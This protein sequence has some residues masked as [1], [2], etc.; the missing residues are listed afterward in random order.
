MVFKWSFLKSCFVYSRN[1]NFNSTS[2]KQLVALETN[3]VFILIM[4]H[5]FLSHQFFF[6]FL[7]ILG[8]LF[9]FPI[10]R[11]FLGKIAYYHSF[12]YLFVS[13][14]K[15]IF[16]PI[17]DDHLAFVERKMMNAI[18]PLPFQQQF[19]TVPDPH[20]TKREISINTIKVGKHDKRKPT[21]VLL[22]GFGAALGFWVCNLKALSESANVY[23]IDLPGFGRYLVE[24]TPHSTHSTLHTLHTL[25]TTTHLIPQ[26]NF[27]T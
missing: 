22:H 21:L 14:L 12:I 27:T 10:L 26:S 19:V 5:I 24:Q 15:C 20:Q 13:V 7:V 25:H 3:K 16:L 8:F 6:F 17:S 18:A 23:A 1:L 11:S 4:I 2:T 9:N